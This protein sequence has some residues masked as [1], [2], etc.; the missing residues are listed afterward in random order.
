[1]T[2]LKKYKGLIYLLLLVIVVPLLVWRLALGSTAKMWRGY[3]RNTTRIETLRAE[4]QA[5]AVPITLQLWEK[6]QIASGLLLESILPLA[7]ANGAQIQKYTPYMSQS[8]NGLALYTAEVTLTGRYS[9]MVRMIQEIETGASA[10]RLVSANF[11]A[12]KQRNRPDPQL[13]LTLIIQQL[14]ET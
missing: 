3:N 11:K 8:A 13:T 14:R 4:Q 7:E 1:M 6:E 12:V 5:G 10:C 2:G 9:G